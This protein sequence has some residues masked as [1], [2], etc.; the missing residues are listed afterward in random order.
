MAGFLLH[1]YFIQS[2]GFLAFALGVAAFLQKNDVRLK[3]L[4]VGQCV[5]L[6][7]HF[8]L[9]G[10]QAGA[11]MAL[12]AAARNTLMLR[13]V[14]VRILASIVFPLYLGL[15]IYN[16]QHWPD[17]LPV[18][19]SIVAAYGIFYL[20]HIPMRLCF[21]FT[22][23]SWIIHNIA[24]GSIGPTLMEIVMLCATLSTIYRLWREEKGAKGK[25]GVVI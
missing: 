3:W 13:G 25:S 19:G 16:F 6:A 4:Q 21:A 5:M 20:R 1:P 11:A 23:I 12:V 22:G 24:V 18:V 10:A 15:G 7:A 8:T 14:N 9:L 17:A 2:L